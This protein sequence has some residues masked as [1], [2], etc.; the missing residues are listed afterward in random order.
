MPLDVT[1]EVI[2]QLD[3]HWTHQ[4]RPRLDGLTDDELFWEPV[5][6]CWSVRRR[7]ESTAPLSY[8]SGEFTWDHGPADSAQPVTTIAWRLAHVAEVLASTTGTFFGG[9][10]VDV[11]SYDYP[12]SALDTLHRLDEEYAAFVAG[13]RAC[14]DAGLA[15]PQGDRSP[16]AFAAAPVARVV[17]YTSVEVVHH[18]AE[19]CLLR[20]LYLRSA[21]LRP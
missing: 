2:D 21:T 1:T 11:E 9:R 15:E 12:G 17:L 6:D 13:I 7:G 14:G 4:L 3:S 8:G 20:D 10:Q 16:P 18:G 5:P 19:A